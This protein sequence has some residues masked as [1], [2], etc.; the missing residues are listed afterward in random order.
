MVAPSTWA[1]ATTDVYIKTNG[2]DT[3][4]PVTLTMGYEF[5]YFHRLPGAT[6]ALADA[7]TLDVNVLGNMNFRDSNMVYGDS[8]EHGS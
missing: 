6:I 8:R 4:A 5:F 3:S 7:G 2:A 1:A